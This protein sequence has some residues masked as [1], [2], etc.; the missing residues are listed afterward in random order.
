MT[1]HAIKFYDLTYEDKIQV[2]SWR[3]NTDVREQ[4]L[5]NETISTENHLRFIDNLK[6]DKRNAYWVV[7]NNDTCIGVI[8]LNKIDLVNKNAYLGIYA[9]PYLKEVS[10]KGSVLMKQLL[11]L[12]FKELNLHTIKL[13]VFEDNKRAIKLYM[14]YGF[15]IEGKLKDFVL[16]NSKFHDLILMGLTN[17][18]KSI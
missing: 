16:R 14:K 7:K 4:M 13:E 9:N 8:Y 1:I 11:F 17:A 2:L 12:A 5:N 15:Y 3:N 10:G 18:N 6:N